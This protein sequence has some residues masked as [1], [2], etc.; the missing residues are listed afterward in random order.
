VS[1][2]RF[3]ISWSRILPN[4]N[5]VSIYF[6]KISSAVSH[7]FNNISGITFLFSKIVNEQAVKQYN[8]LIDALLAA[9]REPFVT[10]YH[11]D[12]R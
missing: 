10:I 6:L 8:T 1:A 2:Y 7:S 11:W 3:S 4:G 12:W 5:G 9:G